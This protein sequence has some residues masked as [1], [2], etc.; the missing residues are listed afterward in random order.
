MV[1]RLLNLC[2]LDLG[3]PEELLG[4]HESNLLG[5]SEHKGFVEINDALLSQLGGSWDNPPPLKEGWERALALEPVAE[6]ARAL[7]SNFSSSP[8][9]GWKDPRTTILLPFWKSL[10]PDLRFVICIRSP[11]EVAQSLARRDGTSLENGGYLWDLY[12]RAAIR[13]TEGCPRLFT[14][15]E[16]FFTDE[17]G[18]AGR[19]VEFCQLPKPDDERILRDAVSSGLRHHTA[20]T[21]QLLNDDSF[22][23][24]Y[25]LAYIGLR[26]LSMQTFVSS[27]S[28]RTREDLISEDVSAFSRLI[29]EFYDHE[30]MD[31]LQSTQ[32]EL[33]RQLASV[34]Q[35]AKE[36]DKLIAELNFQMLAIQRT[37]G[38]KTL[39]RLR[40]I[41]DRLMPAGSRRLNAYWTLRRV[42][43]V[44]LDEPPR[45]FLIKTGYKIRQA[46]RG[47]GI[48]VKTPPQGFTL[49]LN[50]QYQVWLQQHRITPQEI[51]RKKA[52]V[53][54]FTYTPLISIVTPVYNTDE[55]WLRK[56]IESVRDQIYPH[57][58]LCLINDASPKPHVR[59]VLDE[60]AS[61]DP[62][63]RVKHLPQNKGIAE[64][65]THGLSLA[66]GEFVGFLGHDDEIS[67]DALFEVVKRLNED[68]N[69]DLLYSDEDKLELD[70]RRV[71]PFFKPDWSPDLLLSMNYITHFSVFRRSL[72]GEMGGFRRGLDG[73]QGYD[74]LLRFTERTDR[75]AHIPKVLYHWREPPDS[76]AA[77]TAAKPL[78][79]EAGRR[80]LEEALRRR[81][82]GGWVES[83]LPGRYTVRYRLC[84]TPL[85]SII[86]PTKDRWQ[87]LQQCLRSIEEKTSY[88]RYE[89][90][91]LDNDSTEPETVQ[92]LDAIADKWRVYRWPGPFNFSAINN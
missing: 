52:E 48:L 34:R 44:L 59:G 54:A 30:K 12:M 53:E 23:T 43:E 75:I 46:L 26:A 45:A 58:E 36:K 76:A 64:A 10:I 39:E 40:R 69:L 14:F 37:V 72:L 71:E 78:A 7:L 2:G 32:M 65:S 41:Q 57:W 25:K 74:L 4:P 68:P 61:T 13:D 49:D 3:P 67:P 88:A 33:R 35:N 21:L 87:L 86:I 29:E 19:V 47:E 11:L 20:E 84:G 28:G 82:H 77:S 83:I 1:A 27:T 91:I 18:E 24:R 51:A 85:V 50:A 38:W 15:Y 6:K 73:S 42:V 31:Q 8:R 79:H 55:T 63:V 16:D 62:R 22:P 17:L 56:A 70:G 5:H 90:I 92:Y 9:W 66:T 80:A 60:Y 81:G 89:I